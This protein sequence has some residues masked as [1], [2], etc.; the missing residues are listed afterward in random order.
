MIL[1]GLPGSE[2][3]A[4]QTHGSLWYVYIWLF[5]LVCVWITVSTYVIHLR[6]CSLCVWGE[7][8]CVCVCVCCYVDSTLL[9]GPFTD[10]NL[11]GQCSLSV[12]VLDTSSTIP[13]PATCF[14]LSVGATRGIGAHRLA[15]SLLHVIH[16]LLLQRCALISDTPRVLQALLLQQSK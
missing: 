11:P 6:V 1:A 2:C 8:V 9:A 10:S 4:W 16:F 7:N 5:M 14:E 13:A 12:C 3:C 15:S